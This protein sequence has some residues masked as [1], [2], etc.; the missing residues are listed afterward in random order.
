MRWGLL[1]AW[2]GSEPLCLF[3]IL[4]INVEV[5]IIATLT[6]NRSNHQINLGLFQIRRQNSNLYYTYEKD[7]RFLFGV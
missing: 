2:S 1:S 6:R 5:V 4:S 3:A 7:K